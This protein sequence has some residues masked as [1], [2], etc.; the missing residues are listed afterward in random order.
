[1]L[2]G[3]YTKMWIFV[4]TPPPP[5]ADGGVVDVGGS[6]LSRDA[7]EGRGGGGAR[8]EVGMAGS[9]GGAGAGWGGGAGGMRSSENDSSETSKGCIF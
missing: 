6:Q 4:A 3:F 9:A 1:M 2:V 7:G 8:V 5:L